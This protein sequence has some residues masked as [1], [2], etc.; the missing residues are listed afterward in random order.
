[1]KRGPVRDKKTMQT[2]EGRVSATDKDSGPDGELTY[3]LLASDVPVNM[4]QINPDNGVITLACSG[5]LNFDDRSF[6][7]LVIKV[8]DGGSPPRLALTTLPVQVTETVLAPPVFTQSIYRV[9]IQENRPPG[10]LLQ[11]EAKDPDTDSTRLKYSMSGRPSAHEAEDK[12]VVYSNGSIY[13]TS[14]FDADIITNLTADLKVTDGNNEAFAQLQIIIIDVNDN[15]PRLNI[16][17][18][19]VFTV[20]ENISSGSVVTTIGASDA[21]VSNDGFTFW[22]G[23]GGQGKFS[24]DQESGT[25]TVSGQLDRRFATSYNLTVHVS[26][27]GAPPRLAQ[28][29]ISVDVL[30]SNTGPV[31]LD[32][33]GDRTSQFLFNVTED[34]HRGTVGRDRGQKFSLDSVTGNLTVAAPLNYEETSSY[35]LTARVTDNSFVPAF[36]TAAIDI[37]VTNVVEAP[38]WPLPLPVLYLTQTST[39]SPRLSAFSRELTSV[40]SRGDETVEYKLVNQT[41]EFWINTTSGL[42]HTNQT[43]EAR[44]YT[45]TLLACSKGT[46]VCSTANL[47]VVV[48]SDDIL[49]FCPAFYRREISE[50][51]PVN[52]TIVYLPTSKSDSQVLFNITDGNEAGKFGIER[53]TGRVFVNE[54]LDRETTDQFTLIISATLRSSPSETAQAQIIVAILDSPD[55]PP[56]FSDV[57]YKGEITEEVPPISPVYIPGTS[58]NLILTAT[59]AD[60]NP[61]L[62]FSID[63]STDT[64]NGS[65]SIDSNGNLLLM[66]LIDFEAMDFSLGGMFHF[67]LTFSI[68]ES[69]DTSNGSF[70]VDSNGNLLLMKLIDFEAMDF[71]LG[72]MFHFNVNVSDGYFNRTAPITVFVKDIN[73]N[74][75]VFSNDGIVNINVTEGGDVPRSL[76]S[77]QASDADQVDYGRMRY[78]LSMVDPPGI[79][80]PFSVESQTGMLRLERKLDRETIKSYL[81]NFTVTDSDPNHKV[82]QQVLITVTDLNDNS[83]TFQQS[84]YHMNVVEEEDGIGTNITLLASDDDTGSNAQLTYTFG[85]IGLSSSFNLMSTESG[86]LLF[87]VKPLDRELN[88]VITL[89]V[90]ATDNGNPRQTGQCSVVVTV[91]D[92]NDNSPEFDLAGRQRYRASV[93]ENAANN[94]V[95]RVDPPIAVTDAD[96]GENGAPGIQ[97]SLRSM[98]QQNSSV[99]QGL[100]FVVDDISRQLMVRYSSD[101]DTL[102]RESKGSYQIQVV[103]TDELGQGRNATSELIITVT[104]V[105]DVAPYF[106]EA[107]Y[108]F[109]I[110]ENSDPGSEVGTVRAEDDDLIVS[111]VVYGLKGSRLFSIEPFNGVIRVAGSLDRELLDRHD[112]TVSACDQNGCDY[113]D[114]T[115]E[116]TDVNDNCPAWNDTSLTFHLV[117]G[118]GAGSYLG[119]LQANDPDQGLN[120]LVEFYVNDTAALRYVQVS[121]A[122]GVTLKTHVD[123][124]DL[125]KEQSYLSFPVY[126]SDRGAP[127]CTTLGGLKLL[128][129]GVNDNPPQICF[130]DACGVGEI[131]LSVLDKSKADTVIGQVEARDIDTG[132]DGE[133]TFSLSS[134]T[135]GVAELFNISSSGIIT[136]AQDINLGDLRQN[137]QLNGPSDQANSTLIVL[138]L[139]TDKGT[140][141]RSSNATLIVTIV[142]STTD[143]PAFSQF[144]YEME[145]EENSP[146]G[147]VVGTVSATSPRNSQLSYS[148]PV[149]GRLE[150]FTVEPLTGKILTMAVLDRETHAQYQFV[151]SAV[152]PFLP[153]FPASAVVTVRITDKNDNKPKFYQSYISL[154][155]FENDITEPVLAT[156]T[157]QD[158]DEGVNGEIQYSIVED[159]FSSFFSVNGTTGELTLLQPLDREVTQEYNFVVQ[160]SDGGGLTADATVHI[161][162]LDVNDHWPEFSKPVY[163][164]VV[165]RSSSVRQAVTRVFARDKDSGPNAQVVYTLDKSADSLSFTIDYLTG[166]I[167]TIA[168]LP[169]ESYSLVVIAADQGNPSKMSNAS[170]TITVEN[171]NT[172]IISAISVSSSHV[173]L[174]VG[175]AQGTQLA[176]NITTANAAKVDIS[177]GNTEGWFM[178]TPEGK[179]VLQ[180]NITDVAVFDLTITATSVTG[181]KASQKVQVAAVPLR[182]DQP[183]YIVSVTENAAA[184]V[185]LLNLNSYPETLAIPVIVSVTENAAGPVILLNLNSYPETLAIPV[186]YSLS[187]PSDLFKLDPSTGTLTL[188]RQVDREATSVYVLGVHLRLLDQFDGASAA[189]ASVVVRVK[190]LNDN[191][192]SFGS[193]GPTL[194]LNMPEN[195]T[196][197]STLVTITAFDP[198]E[199]LNGLV[200][201][202]ITDGD[203]N[204]FSIGRDTGRLTLVDISQFNK[205]GSFTWRLTV[206]AVDRNGTGSSAS[207]DVEINLVKQI[208]QF[209]LLAPI[210]SSTFTDNQ[211]NIVRQ[212]SNI[213]SLQLVVDDVLVHSDSSG[214]DTNKADVLIHALSPQTNTSVSV[215][216]IRRKVTE[217]ES[218]ISKVFQTY[219]EDVT[220]RKS[221]GDGDFSAAVVALIVIGCVMFLVSIIA[222]IVVVRLWKRK[223]T[224]KESEISK[225]FQTYMED[226]TVR[227]SSGDGDFSAAVVALIVIGCVMF[228]V[229]II[230]IIVVVRLWNRQKAY[231]EREETAVRARQRVEERLAR[232]KET[233][234][235]AASTSSKV[236]DDPDQDFEMGIGLDFSKLFDPKK[237]L[238]RTAE[239]SGD[240][241]TCHHGTDQFSSERERQDNRTFYFK[242]PGSESIHSST[243]NTLPVLDRSDSGM[244]GVLGASS[245]DS[246][247]DHT[248]DACRE[249]PDSASKQQRIIST[250]GKRTA[251]GQRLIE[252]GV[253]SFSSTHESR[254]ARKDPQTVASSDGNITGY[255][256]VGRREIPGVNG[257]GTGY[258]NVG[259]RE[260]PGVNGDGT[261]YFNVGRREIPSANGDGTGYGNVGRREIPGANGD[262][263]GYSNVGRRERLILVQPA[264]AAG[265]T[266]EGIFQTFPQRPTVNV[267]EAQGQVELEFVNPTYHSTDGADSP[268]HTTDSFT[269]L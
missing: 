259:R 89:V 39:C 188:E 198:D 261:G 101:G 21:D 211:N 40:S 208:Y 22:L 181:Y 30:D 253:F 5:C 215:D 268:T 190:D 60:K 225:V 160:A 66:K 267:V 35:S 238:R 246:G 166:E 127:P 27:H 114:L 258:F 245:M 67:N 8:E 47:V 119:T 185:T 222:I 233:S 187:E 81:I 24:L 79:I 195:V 117:E 93:P 168:F 103:A 42:L 177:A 96:V 16:T 51:S 43:L 105:D 180:N 71:S 126:A 143:A 164:A 37:Q 255:A 153:A 62:T 154:N 141:S 250:N 113:R 95:I 227:K 53:E 223:V 57:A 162:V 122:G 99:G 142:T 134:D 186:L 82:V 205:L 175:M 97:F 31:F 224:E 94:T 104:D 252:G 148:V 237:L 248:G 10:F 76:A 209:K 44:E 231:A 130:K 213:L 247:I 242:S 150:P 176:L 174:F 161:Q 228:L 23:N 61:Q 229:S 50:S 196:A 123:D 200:A 263:T 13:T 147:A 182:F 203:T 244:E 63:E 65:F 218:E 121:S 48:R 257:D 219:M 129:S 199:G 36:S 7:T 88:S 138:L 56:E 152:D 212:L 83:P 107:N 183:D 269:R 111:L 68:D 49:A 64:S 169:K 251:S 139:A 221:S 29:R 133:V 179:I 32:S 26:D 14:S 55:S 260:I 226:V 109:R 256:N 170:V 201:Y 197:P 41:G 131:R 194:R 33:R 110:S 92:V 34:A 124:S 125:P 120:G 85:S 2:P 12:I 132:V 207:L 38:R 165:I 28:A 264:S 4:F 204:V 80:S 241:T 265:F 91:E 118:Q 236:S 58:L 135:D 234:K 210:S 11:V 45:L 19:S 266:P 100:P 151:V 136:L 52:Q 102:D 214:L 230:A 240:M 1:M 112:M 144:S 46:D 191:V 72:G 217:K 220:V 54:S 15:D 145:I 172:D 262:V 116:I 137:G 202:S 184:P 167:D 18:F 206:Q 157:A 158:D 90:I 108:T 156:L 84:T 98:G 159:K 140:N 189:N 78:S 239:S 149:V 171:N 87:T 73:D 17:D 128:V 163:E 178:L 74:F 173:S 254:H 77:I 193:T 115:V 6:Y 243:H 25:L 192:P 75:P 146:T 232:Q 216:T 106:R 155:I 249:S 86:V 70:S 235:A 59:D 9:D 20:P 69:T 3:S